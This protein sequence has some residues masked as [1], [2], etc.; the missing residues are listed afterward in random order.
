[1]TNEMFYEKLNELFED[2]EWDS[3]EETSNEKVLEVA[4]GRFTIRQK[5]DYVNGIREV[6]IRE[7]MSQRKEGD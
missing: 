6:K 2:M 1:M 4:T 7:D 5:I 3:E